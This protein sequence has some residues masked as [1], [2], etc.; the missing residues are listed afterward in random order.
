MQQQKEISMN[1]YQ[2]PIICVTLCTLFLKHCTLTFNLSQRK[3]NQEFRTKNRT[4][5]RTEENM[6]WQSK[7]CRKKKEKFSRLFS[8][9]C[10]FYSTRGKCFTFLSQDSPRLPLPPPLWLS[11][12]F[13]KSS[14]LWTYKCH[15]SLSHSTHSSGPVSHQSVKGDLSASPVLARGRLFDEVRRDG[16]ES[17]LY[18]LAPRWAW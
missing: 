9:Q 10:R 18:T 16:E 2:L 4:Q 5:L 13:L 7:L 17:G 11:V 14:A 12:L 3:Y 6:Q 15:V 1:F 8:A